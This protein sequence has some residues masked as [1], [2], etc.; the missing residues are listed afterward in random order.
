M[1]QIR[2]RTF[3]F[4]LGC[5]VLQSCGFHPLYETEKSQNN[6][7]Y[8]SPIK[9]REGQILRNDLQS[10]FRSGAKTAQTPYVLKVTLEILKGELGFRRDETSRRTRITLRATYKLIDRSS[11][12]ELL[13]QATSVLTGYSVGSSSSFASFPL[14]IS[15]KDAIKRGLSQLSHD[16]HISISSFLMSLKS[17]NVQG[18]VIHKT[19]PT[20][21]GDKDET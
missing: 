5:L 4:V 14:I 10:F 7:V 19:Q 9:D 13:S 2:V 11:Q 17:S 12:Q 15:E 1:L 8:I 3:L 6:E 16:I 18:S 21:P 20:K